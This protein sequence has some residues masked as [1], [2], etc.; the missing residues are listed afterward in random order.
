M[1]DEAVPVKDTIVFD[2][3]GTLIDSF[4]RSG[5]EYGK[6]ILEVLP[7]VK[8]KPWRDY[9]NVTD[10]GIIKE[11]LIDNGIT[12]GEE[13]IIDRI[14]DTFHRNIEKCLNEQ[15][16]EPIS[17]AI[18]FLNDCRIRYNVGIATGCWRRSGEI[19]L[20]T[21][22]FDITDTVL[23]SSCDHYTREGILEH[24]LAQLGVGKER[25][26]Y[27]GD[28][29]WDLKTTQNLGWDFIGIGEKLKGQCE[30]WFPDYSFPEEIYQLIKCI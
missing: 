15:A 21:A 23:S 6:A 17:G 12:E 3:D 11:V 1:K 26:V 25:V 29:V 19:K 27:L 22:G 20:G 8:L 28:A 10:T 13:G 2:I 18:D 24:C 16:C 30:H 5:Q 9:A 7:D 4:K 14:R